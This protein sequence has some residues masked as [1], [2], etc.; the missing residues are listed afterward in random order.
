MKKPEIC[1]NVL[2]LCIMYY[3][4][5]IKEKVIN[6]IGQI[7]L[8]RNEEECF[9]N[10]FLHLDVKGYKAFLFSSKMKSRIGKVK[11]CNHHWRRVKMIK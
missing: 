4:L 2:I 1:N 7:Y 9:S 5:L 10:L 3:Y 11:T 6:G 8:G